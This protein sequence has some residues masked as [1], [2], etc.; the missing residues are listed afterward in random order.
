MKKRTPL[1]PKD[2]RE[3]AA[4]NRRNEDVITPL[5]EIKRLHDLVRTAEDYRGLVQQAWDGQDLGHMVAIHKL[6]V[7]LQEEM[8]NIRG[9][10]PPG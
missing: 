8:A 5:W 6:R 1:T 9:I 2:L 7:I 3:I 4:G 10:K